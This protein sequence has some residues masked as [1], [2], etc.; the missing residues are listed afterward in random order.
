[1]NHFVMGKGQYKIFIIMIQHRESHLIKIGLS[2]LGIRFWIRDFSVRNSGQGFRKHIQ[3]TIIIRMK[4][5]SAHN[6]VKVLTSMKKS[7]GL[8]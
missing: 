1:M 8:I 4:I 5:R 6:V 2:I 7:P 3:S